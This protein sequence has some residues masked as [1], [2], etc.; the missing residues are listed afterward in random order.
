M[1]KIL[2]TS[3][4]SLI[5]LLLLSSCGNV[6]KLPSW[7]E[8]GKI[9]EIKSF[10]DSCCDEKSKNYV[11]K[12]DRISTWDIDGTIILERNLDNNEYMPR[13]TTRAAYWANPEDKISKGLYRLSQA[14]YYSQVIEG[15][16]PEEVIS[17]FDRYMK[18]KDFTAN[19]KLSNISYKPMV[20]I[21]NYL[22]EHDFDV[23]FLSGSFRYAVYALMSYQ[24]TGLDFEHCMGTDVSTTYQV[25]DGKGKITFNADML[26]PSINDEKAK[27]IATQVGKTPIIAF[28]N[29]TVDKEMLQYTFSNPKYSTLGVIINH[30]DSYREYVYDYDKVH[31]MCQE[32]GA[33]EVSMKDDFKYLY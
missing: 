1:K 18:E 31:S 9:K 29:S 2:T 21:Y 32:I 4:I 17:I 22:K 6:N 13:N 11:P 33:L 30:D 25:V 24:V 23:F 15:F 5:T 7:N 27:K 19:R 12:E 26:D 8:N 28:G 20:E 3:T 14:A 10:I 16:T